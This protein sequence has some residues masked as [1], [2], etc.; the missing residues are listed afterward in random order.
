MW[1]AAL[2]VGLFALWELSCRWGWSDGFLVSC[3]SRIWQTLTS[4]DRRRPALA[5]HRRLLLETVVGFTAGTLLGTAV[6]H[7]YVVVGHGWPASP[8]H[9]WW[10]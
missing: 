6:G 9:T 3:P 8:T 2:L 7:R 1:Q 4:H 5:S 10:C